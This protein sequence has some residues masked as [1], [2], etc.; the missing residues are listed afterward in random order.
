LRKHTQNYYGRNNFNGDAASMILESG[1]LNTN[2]RSDAA[3]NL[4]EGYGSRSAGLDASRVR[5]RSLSLN[6]TLIMKEQIAST[7]AAKA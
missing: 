1:T 2:D 4:L 5:T 6:R 3:K 7:P